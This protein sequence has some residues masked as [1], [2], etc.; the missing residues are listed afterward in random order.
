MLSQFRVMQ[1]PKITSGIIAMQACQM[2]GLSSC[3]TSA[4]QTARR[5]VE[6]RSDS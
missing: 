4:P 6:R 1:D 2:K 5:R 3:V